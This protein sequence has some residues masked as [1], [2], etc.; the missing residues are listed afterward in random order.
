MI[1]ER[2]DGPIAKMLI[3]GDQDS[4]LFYGGRQDISIIGPFLA[5]FGSAQ[6]IDAIGPKSFGDFD[7]EHLIEQDSQSARRGF[8]FAMLN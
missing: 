7:A 1:R 5:A 8:E 4:I 3:N 6:D 2:K